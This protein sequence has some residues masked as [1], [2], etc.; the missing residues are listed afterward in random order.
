MKIHWKVFGMTEMCDEIGC[1]WLQ[2]TLLASATA[3]EVTVWLT[4]NR[5]ANYLHTFQDFSGNSFFVEQNTCITG[6]I[7][8]YI[9]SCLR[10]S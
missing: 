4:S 9:L 5:F 7:I 10:I 8:M 2:D 3:E 6:H 1:C